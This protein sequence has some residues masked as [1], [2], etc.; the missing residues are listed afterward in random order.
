M[1]RTGKLYA[2]LDVTNGG[3]IMFNVLLLDCFAFKKN[4]I[5]WFF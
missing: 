3:I 4:I 2:A 1:S 5:Q